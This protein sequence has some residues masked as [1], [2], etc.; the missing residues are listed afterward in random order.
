MTSHQYGS[1]SAI[2]RRIITGYL[3]FRCIMGR[4]AVILPEK[5]T[6]DTNNSSGKESK[7]PVK[8][9]GSAVE[10]SLGAASDR[11][12]AITLVSILLLLLPLKL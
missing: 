9:S 7:P 12:A 10:V 1:E 6:I 8:H 11:D 5:V 3:I 4:N 2:I